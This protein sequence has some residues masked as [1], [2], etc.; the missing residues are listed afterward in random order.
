MSKGKS[1]DR[2]RFDERI[3]EGRV[4]D[5]EKNAVYSLNQID[6]MKRKSDERREDKKR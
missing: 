6:E 3:G 2:E 4:A 1:N 5:K